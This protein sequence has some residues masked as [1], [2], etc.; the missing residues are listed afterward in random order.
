MP[1]WKLFTFG[2]SWLNFPKAKWDPNNETLT[3]E[4]FKRKCVGSAECYEQNG[5]QGAESWNLFSLSSHVEFEIT[6]K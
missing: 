5:E 1:M 2:S 4:G 3:P 6:G